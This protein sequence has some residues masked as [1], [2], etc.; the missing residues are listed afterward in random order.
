MDI[1]DNLNYPE[2]TK[3]LINYYYNQCPGSL[4]PLFLLYLARTSKPGK[5]LRY[6]WK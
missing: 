6:Y 1:R 4:M 5:G 2:A 3:Q